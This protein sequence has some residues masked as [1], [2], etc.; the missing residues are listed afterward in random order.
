MTQ[1]QNDIN[2]KMR[3]IIVDWI[4]EVTFKFKLRQETLYLSINLID[5]FLEKKRISREIL[6]LVAVSC[7]SLAAKYEEIYPPEI[8]DYSYITDK[9]YT[10]NQIL[11]MEYDVLAV[12][13]FDLLH[14]SP[15]DFLT[16]LFQISENS[17]KLFYLAEYLIEITL[18]EY[19]M[20][21]YSSLVKASCSIYIARKILKENDEIAW[22]ESFVN[23]TK[24]ENP[25]S[26]CQARRERRSRG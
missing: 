11:K 5:R 2:D 16:R 4:I 7:L 9:T 26:M 1:K 24:I 22:K 6:Q 12:L 18:L 25:A 10:K 21:I 3:S 19:K 20:I 23:F 15:Y 8:R 14:V 13:D 17:K